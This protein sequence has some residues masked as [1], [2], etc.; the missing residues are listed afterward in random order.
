MVMSQRLADKL[1]YFI[2]YYAQQPIIRRALREGY[3]ERK[4]EPPPEGKGN[5]MVVYYLT[6]RS[7]ALLENVWKVTVTEFSGLNSYQLAVLEISYRQL[8]RTYAG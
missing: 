7:K 5:Y 2:L 6:Q 8:Q 3:V 4:E 1:G